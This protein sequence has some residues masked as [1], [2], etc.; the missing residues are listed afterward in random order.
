MAWVLHWAGYCL[1]N[2]SVSDL[3]LEA[4]FVIDRINLGLIF[5]FL[6]FLFFWFFF[7]LFCFAFLFLFLLFMFFVLLCFLTRVS[8]QSRSKLEICWFC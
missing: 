7:V 8:L 3:S 1:A 4:A 2:P 6:D 5:C